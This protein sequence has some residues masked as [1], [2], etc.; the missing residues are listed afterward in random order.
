[1][2]DPDFRLL[3]ERGLPLAFTATGRYWL[4]VERAWQ[5]AALQFTAEF[6]AGEIMGLRQRSLAVKG[7][8]PPPR[9]DADRARAG[10]AEEFD[11]RQIRGR[12]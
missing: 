12:T 2:T 3:A 10:H 8:Q 6:G 9:G 4:A 5:P 11:R 7:M 1:M